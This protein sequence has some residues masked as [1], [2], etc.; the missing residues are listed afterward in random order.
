[1]SE[2]RKLFWLVLIT[3]LVLATALFAACSADI[4]DA[5]TTTEPANTDSATAAD[6]AVKINEQDVE[7]ASDIAEFFDEAIGSSATSSDNTE[8]LPADTEVDAKGIPV[9]FTE[10]GNPY[11]GN[12]NAPVIIEEFSDFQ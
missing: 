5:V 1:M 3:S 8:A 9:G 6:D 7:A 2:N 10:N 4:P 12:H 11:R